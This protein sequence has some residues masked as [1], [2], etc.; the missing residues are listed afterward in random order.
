MILSAAAIVSVLSILPFTRALALHARQ[1]NC[2]FVCPDTDVDGNSLSTLTVDESTVSCSYSGTLATSCVYDLATGIPVEG[3]DG[4]IQQAVQRCISKRSP[5]LKQAV[6]RRGLVEEHS[7]KREPDAEWNRRPSPS[8]HPKR[9]VPSPA[10]HKRSDSPSSTPSTRPSPSKPGPQPP[11]QQPCNFRCPQNDLAKNPLTD[12][13]IRETSL[14]CSF[15]TPH[16]NHCSFCK[17]STRTGLLLEDNND[18][19]CPQTASP[20]RPWDRRHTRRAVA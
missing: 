5:Q 16:C 1:D 7:N 10:R 6:M 4:C 8:P 20:V 2:A 3:S 13:A 14:F 9:A 15:F 12:E 11:T 17:Y 18:G 19:N